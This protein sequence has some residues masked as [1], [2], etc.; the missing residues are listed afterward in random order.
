MSRAIHSCAC[1]LG[2]SLEI[3]AG[4]LEIMGGM[5]EARTVAELW[6]AKWIPEDHHRAGTVCTIAISPEAD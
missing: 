2:D 3:A 5:N 4:A 6:D 1:D